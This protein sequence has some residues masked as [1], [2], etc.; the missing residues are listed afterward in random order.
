MSSLTT[1]EKQVL[2]KLLQMGD[3]YVLNFSDRTFAEFFRDDVQTDITDGKYA[4][5]SGSKANRM[6]GFWKASEDALVGTSILKLLS[7][8]D[9]QVLIGHLKRESFS[10]ELIQRARAIAA[11]LRGG[12]VAGTVAETEDEFVTKEF[13]K[14]S[15]DKLGLDSGITAI[16]KQRVEE[17]RKS[18]GAKA[19]LGVIFLCG[20]TLEGVLLGIAC[21]KAR[22]FNQSSLS[23]KDKGTGKVK[24]FSDWTLNDFINVARDLKLVGEDVKKFSHA[25]RDFRNYIHPYQQLSTGFDPDEHTAKICWQVLQAAIVQLSN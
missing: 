9:T 7:Y 2:E 4:Y 16:L 10:D 25:L 11:R 5:A 14:I 8:I 23:P 19:P 6:R 13:G 1:N 20:S 22:E 17:I 21:I 24:Q 15:L 12:S 18:L 3:G